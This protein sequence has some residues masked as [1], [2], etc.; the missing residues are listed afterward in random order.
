MGK[1]PGVD[2]SIGLPAGWAALSMQQRG[3]DMADGDETEPGHEPP[4]E[5]HDQA[6]FF[7]LARR[8]KEAWN[9]W[10]RDPANNDVHVSFAGIDFSEAPMDQIDFS[11]FKFG[12]R[13]DFSNCKWR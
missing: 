2:L 9:A 8:G 5:A 11:A 6:F 7:A 1:Q 4:A 10:R 13:A 12:D 3:A